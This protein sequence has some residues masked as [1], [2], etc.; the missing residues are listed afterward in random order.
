MKRVATDC[1]KL[2]TDSC[3]IERAKSLVRVL[4]F[5]SSAMA[6]NLNKALDLLLQYA[7][8]ASR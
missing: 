1:Q 7:K 8:L 3:S 4:S 2:V 6:D 5:M